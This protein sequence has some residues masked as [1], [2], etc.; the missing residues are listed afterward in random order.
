M[1]HMAKGAVGA[2]LL[3][4]CIPPLQSIASLPACPQRLSESGGHL[5]I[6]VGKE[7]L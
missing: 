6:P 7:D 2:H 1:M 3:S 4:P 5:L